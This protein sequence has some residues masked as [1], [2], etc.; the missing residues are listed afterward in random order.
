MHGGWVAANH[1]NAAHNGPILTNDGLKFSLGNF[2]AAHRGYFQ[3]AIR[4]FEYDLATLLFELG[5]PMELSKNS[6]DQSL[7]PPS[8]YLNTKFQGRRENVGYLSAL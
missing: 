2:L 3:A 4:P 6:F 5:C 7:K 8:G 1:K